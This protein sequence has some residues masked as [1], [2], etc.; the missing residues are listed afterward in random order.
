MTMTRSD[1]LDAKEF[2]THICRYNKAYVYTSTS[3]FG[4]LDGAVFDGQGPSTYKSRGKPTIKSDPLR[5]IYPSF[6]LLRVPFSL[7][8]FSFRF[9]QVHQVP[10]NDLFVHESL[11]TTLGAPHGQNSIECLRHRFTWRFLSGPSLRRFRLNKSHRI[12]INYS[13][14][15]GMFKLRDQN[16]WPTLCTTFVEV[17]DVVRFSASPNLIVTIGFADIRGRVLRVRAV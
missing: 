17:R 3:D 15:P 5:D 4:H 13:T 12:G 16:P 8:R 2:R 7:Q 14:L 1:V 9:E 10:V 6:L 11:L